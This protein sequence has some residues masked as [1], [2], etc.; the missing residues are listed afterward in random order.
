MVDNIYTA[1][2][3]AVPREVISYLSHSLDKFA[4][5]VPSSWKKDNDDDFFVCLV[6]MCVMFFGINVRT[7][8]FEP[9][10]RWAVK[11]VMGLDRFSYFVHPS[12]FGVRLIFIDGDGD[13]AFVDSHYKGKAKVRCTT[14]L[15]DAIKGISFGPKKMSVAEC[16]KDSRYFFNYRTKR[17]QFRSY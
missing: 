13:I 11:T 14:S 17:Y 16:V 12:E 15:D 1:P 6:A 4:G 8:P 3:K 10:T 2:K 5:G 9:K 7:W